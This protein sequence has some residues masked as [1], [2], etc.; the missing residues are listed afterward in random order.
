MGGG[1][2]V[3]GK[4]EGGMGREREAHRKTLARSINKCDLCFEKPPNMLIFLN[5]H[6]L[7]A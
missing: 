1:G 2:G 6:V 7:N 3:V 5:F 4:E